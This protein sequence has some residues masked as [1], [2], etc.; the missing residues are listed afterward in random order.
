MQRCLACLLTTFSMFFCNPALTNRDSGFDSGIEEEAFSWNH[1]PSWL[2]IESLIEPWNKPVPVRAFKQESRLSN[3]NYPRIV[4]DGS[5][6]VIIVALAE[7][8]CEDSDG[9]CM[10]LFAQR[11]S[12]DG[13]RLWGDYGIRLTEYYPACMDTM[14]VSGFKII[15]DR[16][17]GIYIISPA[18]YSELKL[19]ANRITGDGRKSFMYLQSVII[20]TILNLQRSF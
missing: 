18:D 9:V 16:T 17:G 1:P 19:Y 11:I 13:V 15:S 7:A 5:G 6:G 8:S 20:P 14:L 3:C 12:A 10:T 2:D 4:S